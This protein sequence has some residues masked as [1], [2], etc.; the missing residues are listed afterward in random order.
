MDFKTLVSSHTSIGLRPF[1]TVSALRVCHTLDQIRP[2]RTG[3]SGFHLIWVAY[4]EPSLWTMGTHPDHTYMLLLNPLE[5][6]CRPLMIWGAEE[7]SKMNLFF[8]RQCLLKFIFC[9]GR[10]FEIYFFPDMHLQKKKILDFLWPHPQIINGRPL[11]D[12]KT[13]FMTDCYEWTVCA[14][15]KSCQHFLPYVAYIMYSFI[16]LFE[17]ISIQSQTSK[18]LKYQ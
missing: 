16:I 8:P 17:S 3:F 18:P 5:D 15:A 11:N 6:S 14:L 13:T 4:M 2:V 1:H 10:P 9:W 7:K 12:C